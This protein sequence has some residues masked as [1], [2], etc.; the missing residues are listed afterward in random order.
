MAYEKVSVPVRSPSIATSIARANDLVA[1]WADLAEL[2]ATTV[3]YTIIA[4]GSLSIT[5][6]RV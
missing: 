2:E 4:A 5:L 3:D 1:A 6:R